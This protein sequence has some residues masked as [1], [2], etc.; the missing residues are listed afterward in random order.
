MSKARLIA[1]S[2]AGFLVSSPLA[3][4]DPVQLAP[5]AP[6]ASTND[7]KDAIVCHA[8]EPMIGTRLSAHRVCRTQRE[9]DQVRLDSQKQVE[10]LQS[11]AGMK[12]PGSQ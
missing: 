9:W 3:F 7:D 11:G 10:L 5:S 2:V 8:G 4:A 12:Y 1:V 6:V